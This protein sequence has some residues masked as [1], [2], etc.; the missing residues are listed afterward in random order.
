MAIRIIR[1]SPE[2]KAQVQQQQTMPQQQPQDQGI[3]SQ[4]AGSLG[5]LG[6]SLGK[7]VADVATLPGRAG[8]FVAE[9]LGSPFAKYGPDVSGAIKETEEKIRGGLPKPIG[10][11]GE[12]YLNKAIEKL[13]AFYTPGGGLKNAVGRILGSDIGKGLAGWMGAG[14]V[15]KFFGSAIGG[16]TASGLLSHKDLK[17]L[18]S[19]NYKEFLNS[20]PEGAK[21]TLSNGKEV[22]NKIMKGTYKDFKGQSLLPDVNKWLKDHG[23]DVFDKILKPKNMGIETAFRDGSQR[24]NQLIRTEIPKSFSK[25]AKD[26]LKGMLKDV[27]S[28]IKSDIVK[29]KEQYPK[30]FAKG[31]IDGSSLSFA[32][33]NPNVIRKVLKFAG[34]PSLSTGG[35]LGAA[36]TAAPSKITATL[37]GAAPYVAAGGLLGRGLVEPAMMAAQSPAARDYYKQAGTQTLQGLLASLKV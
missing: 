18:E 2:Q 13:P 26:Q 22:Y 36:Y 24:M 10:F 1:R 33:N 7:G 27:S 16:L 35:L 17:V 34:V 31:L 21:T 23:S 19:K 4:V 28:A 20:I 15:G 3:L 12:E 30:L 8:A 25:E 9:K 11:T 14:E 6:V 32:R 29:S 5:N 37:G